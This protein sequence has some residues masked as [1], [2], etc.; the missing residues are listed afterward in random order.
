M[1]FALFYPL[2]VAGVT[3]VVTTVIVKTVLTLKSAR[4][5]FPLIT[6]VGIYTFGARVVSPC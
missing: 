1:Y 3:A 6:T 4:P 2:A 5:V